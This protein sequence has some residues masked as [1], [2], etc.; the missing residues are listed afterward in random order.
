M[1]MLKVC[2][3]AAVLFMSW[4]SVAWA[5]PN[6]I[7]LGYDNCAAC[8][9]SPTGGGLLTTYGVGIDAAQNLKPQ[10]LNESEFAARDLRW[11]AYD[12]RLSLS[13]DR[14]PP[15]ATG[16][17]F[18]T[19]VRSAF[20]LG[21]H[22]LVYAASL[23][24]PT[25][26]RTRTSGAVSVRMSKFYWLFQ[27]KDGVSLTVGRDDLPNGNGSGSLSFARRTTTPSVT[28]TPTQVKLSWWNDRW[29][30][31]TYGFGPD[32]NETSPQFEAY[33]AGAMV[34]ADVW[35]D[36]AV[37]GISTR[38]SRAGAYDRNA[39]SAFLRIGFTKHLGVVLE[40]EITDRTTDRGANFTHLG[41]HSEVFWVP[42][43]WLQTAL[44]VDQVKTSGGAYSYRISPEAQIRLTRN[45]SLSFDST[46]VVTGGA[47]SGNGRTRAYSMQ[48]LVKALE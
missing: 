8:H 46:D 25:L 9:V 11:L 14:E 16:Y 35:K 10:D 15:D 47:T 23:S 30:V 38:A 29:Q 3:I 7:R 4:S 12:V 22:R 13:L 17:G 31:T 19:G 42:F 21:G 34:G 1:H 28:T 36:R 37:V 20:G 27:P 2:A 18:S 5:R 26:A 43:D 40:H 33:G 32:G 48:L 24:S 45:L 41:G 44:G 6:Q 39:A